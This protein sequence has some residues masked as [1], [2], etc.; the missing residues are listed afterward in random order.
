MTMKNFNQVKANFLAE[1]AS[2]V[3]MEEIPAE[4]V[5]NGDQTGIHVILAYSWTM[6]QQGATCVG[7]PPDA[8]QSTSSPQI[9]TSHP[10]QTTGQ[11]RRLHFLTST[12]SLFPLLVGFEMT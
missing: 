6:E 7:R 9:G 10:V 4:L 5:F 3:T 11:T 8:I 1:I 2:A 12:E